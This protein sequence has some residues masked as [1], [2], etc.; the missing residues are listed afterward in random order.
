MS[1]DRNNLDKSSSSYL[2]MHKDNPINWQEWEESVLRYAKDN[3]KLILV[4]I[5][6]STCHWCHVML[7]DTFSN[8]D[9][10]KR[11]NE[12]FV[13]I[14][15][16]RE[17][18]P[19]LDSYFMSF[20]NETYGHGGWPLNVFLSPDLKPFLAITYAGSETKY[21]MP[22]FNEI[23]DRCLDF[24][25]E[26]KSKLV[27]YVMNEPDL[28]RIEE[29]KVFENVKKYYDK[30][31]GGFGSTNKFPPHCTLMF[32]FH[33]LIENNNEELYQ[34]SINTINSI[35]NGGLND[36]I[37]G[38]YFRYSVDR[39]WS[40]PHFE[41]MLYDQAMMLINLS[42]AYKLTGD[43]LYKYELEK[44]ILFLKNLKSDDD[45]LYNN[46]IDAESEGVEGKYYLFHEA[47]LENNLSQQE[48]TKLTLM[49]DLVQF[50][51]MIHIKRK[52]LEYEDSL[53]NKIKELRSDKEKPF[54]DN[55]KLV[56]SNSL[57]GIGLV[58]SYRVLGDD[59]L[60]KEA[61][62][63]YD[64][65]LLNYF[66]D[67]RLYHSKNDNEYNKEEFL[68]TFS[69]F[70]LFSTYI[71]EELRI[72]KELLE[73]FYS[74]VK[75]YRKPGVW[76]ES[77]DNSFEII[78]SNHDHP[79]LS[80]ISMTELAILRYEILIETEY[81]SKEYSNSLD[82]D[83]YNLL[84]FFSQGNIK[85]VINPRKI[86][87]SLLDLNCI[88][89]KSKFNRLCYKGSCKEFKDESDLVKQFS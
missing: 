29:D 46:A 76:L 53:T 24:Y 61:H 71:F 31:F 50:N 18:R 5:G 40:I 23:L 48:L 67:I 70:Y 56:S 8:K 12:D 65:I 54:M 16:D 60:L 21:G 66:D 75:D 20:I 52:R 19:D 79:I 85:S 26:N 51:D 34:I 55:K 58:Y 87:W 63:I 45:E 84:A 33:Y 27:N 88:Q 74:R 10:A 42:L 6:Y 35:I 83:F 72:G 89:L 86:N 4:S 64:E 3:N 32:L 22:S 17:E 49:Y 39:D 37:E 47:E 82:N 44:L 81:N 43:N 77:N 57:L 28:T 2:K 9:I 62:Q 38:G 59:N 13:C 36:H 1:Y 15:I 69:S 68:E 78:A 73:D 14:K 30:E 25:E 41:K 11:L 80:G 7:R